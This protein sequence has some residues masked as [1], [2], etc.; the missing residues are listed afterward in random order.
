MAEEDFLTNVARMI[1]AELYF[2][3][4]LQ[5]AREMYGKSYFALGAGEKTSVDQA[6][7]GILAAYYQA[8]TAENL[9][10]QTTAQ[11]AGFQAQAQKSG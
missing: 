6:V 1:A 11:P 5:A 9:Q 3:A 4:G 10:K 2:I 8:V 7:F